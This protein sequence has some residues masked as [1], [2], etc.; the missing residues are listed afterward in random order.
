MS[1]KTSARERPLSPFML[2][3]YYRWQLTS[4][5]SILH[6]LTGLAMALGTLFLTA[7]MLSAASGPVAYDGFLAFARSGLGKLLLLGFSWALLYHLCNGI[8][9]LVWDAGRAFELK[10][11]YLGGWIVV[12]ASLLLTAAAWAL[13]CSF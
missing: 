4:A 8:R 10:N 3:Q 13:A 1:A 9:H 6:R 12:A 5:L 2:G 11:V 7:W